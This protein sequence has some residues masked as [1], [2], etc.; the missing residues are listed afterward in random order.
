MNRT[1]YWRPCPFFCPESPDHFRSWETLM[2]ACAGID[3]PVTLDVPESTP[4]PRGTHDLSGVSITVTEC[5]VTVRGVPGARCAEDDL[6]CTCDAE[7][8]CATLDHDLDCPMFGKASK[9]VH[10][11]GE[12]DG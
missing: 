11:E 8:G 5:R 1:L 9:R 4:F 12:I 10:E 7:P 6:R 2:T 3:G